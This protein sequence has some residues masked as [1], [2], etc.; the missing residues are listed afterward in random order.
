MA[1][2]THE[3]YDDNLAIWEKCEDSIQGEDALHKADKG[4]K[5]KYLRVLNP[6]D[7]SAF[8]VERNNAYVYGA[9]FQNFSASTLQGF[10]GMAFRKPPVLPE[11]PGEID[12]ILDNADGSGLSLVQQSRKVLSEVAKK[13]RDG[14]LVEMPN[15]EG[16]QVTRAQVAE[17]LRATIKLYCAENILD[18]YPNEPTAKN[19]LSYVRLREMATK[20]VAVGEKEKV[21]RH[22]VLLLDKGKY[23]QEI[24]EQDESGEWDLK[25]E[26]TPMTSSGVPFD[27]I[28]FHFCGSLNNNP[29]VDKPLILDIVNV[30]LGMYQEDANQRASSF[31][32]SA[33]TAHIADNQFFNWFHGGGDDGQHKEVRFGESSVIVTGSD[34][35]VNIV[36]PPENSLSGAIKESD[37]AV[38]IALG[39]QVIQPGGA[40]ETAEAVR[41]KAGSTASKLSVAVQ[42]VEDFYNNALQDV[43]MFMGATIPETEQLEMN[44]EFFDERVS[45][46]MLDKMVAAWLAGAISKNVLDQKLVEGSVIPENTDLEKM[47]EE[48]DEAIP[49]DGEPAAI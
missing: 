23:R 8:N 41:L 15:T 47:N 40:A 31:A 17:G 4:M 3:Q 48:V 44:Q 5:G 24:Y 29:D 14:G 30:N 20:F 26:Y 10:L 6:S 33:A 19:P 9:R 39:A 46:E 18:W 16:K 45:P 25:E 11:L 32:Y 34:G 12:Y 13:G 27:H 43:A 2:V 1:D 21:E 7:K 36:S 22:I 28:P 37:L 42:N 49:D 38:L 35:K